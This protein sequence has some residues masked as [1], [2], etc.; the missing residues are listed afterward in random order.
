MNYI[1]IKLGDYINE[2]YAN[3]L[4]AIHKKYS[5]ISFNN[6]NYSIGGGL[7]G[8]RYASRRHEDAKIDGGKLTLGKA[9]QLFKK[10]TGLELDDIRDIIKLAVPNMEWHHAGKLPK[11]YGG[12]MKKTF[13]INSEQISDIAENWDIY[14]SKYKIKEEKNKRD[15]DILNSKKKTE[16]NFLKKYATE[17]IRVDIIPKYFHET[18]REMK[19]KH[20]WF[21]SHNHSYNLPE[22]Y[23]GWKFRSD[24][25]Y[26]EFL[27]I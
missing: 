15:A 3:K 11:S 8:E 1:F 6:D 5:E 20:G 14:L 25:K 18:N 9:T 4:M 10:A 13:F 17:V 12:G 22:Y 7:D 16:L 27:N 24:R 19:G 21:D 26:R 2:S 23:S